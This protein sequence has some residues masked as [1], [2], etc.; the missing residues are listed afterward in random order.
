MDVFIEPIG[1]LM[2]EFTKLP[3]V[4]QKTAQRYAYR[5]INMT[6]GEARAFADAIVNIKRKVRFCRVCRSEERRIGRAHV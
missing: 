2:N 5:V 1:R 6:E 4:G 3:G